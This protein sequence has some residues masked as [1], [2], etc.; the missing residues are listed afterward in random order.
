M[1]L[2]IKHI[3]YSVLNFALCVIGYQCTLAAPV[4]FNWETS[5][6]SEPVAPGIS[7]G[8]FCCSSWGMVE[9]NPEEGNGQPIEQLDYWDGEPQASRRWLFEST[10]DGFYVIRSAC[11]GKVLDA[12]PDGSWGVKTW[13][14]AGV[15]WHQWRIIPM[16]NAKY[17]I[18]NR[19]TGLFLTVGWLSN[20]LGV[21]IG[22]YSD[23]GIN[24]GQMFHLMFLL[25]D[26]N[27][28]FVISSKA[29]FDAGTGV[30]LDNLYSATNSGAT[31]G[32]CYYWGG[33]N[34]HFWFEASSTYESSVIIKNATRGAVLDADFSGTG[35][36]LWN[37]SAGV[38]WQQWYVEH[39]SGPWFTI[40]SRQTLLY[41]TMNWYAH[42]E[43]SPQDTRP[44]L[45]QWNWTNHPAQH[46]RFDEVPNIEG[47]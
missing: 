23:C 2:I 43:W 26:S 27:S 24:D 35:V 19:H 3:K 22:Q 45:I 21:T 7:Y 37:D 9:A 41:L 10:G 20:Q 44:I 31:I 39:S 40:R 47:L 29:A 16:G 14:Y 1:N 38:T 13:E 42:W 17:K 4:A 36:E 28:R 18:Q 33:V 34:Q 30:V 8:I 5:T 12:N 15:G 32:Q 46:W 11:D 6:S 25:G